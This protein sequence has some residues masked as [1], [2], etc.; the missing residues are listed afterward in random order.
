[1]RKASRF[2][3]LLL[4]SAYLVGAWSSQALASTAGVFQFVA[5]DV[6]VVLAEGSERPAA[7]GS[8][9]SVGD[10]VTTAKASTAQ[11]KMGD[12]AIIVV[13]PESKLTV[14]EFSYAGKED[15]TE[16]VQFRL[17]Q[18]GFRSVTGA[19]GHTN[20]GNYMIET[21]IA[22]IG[23]RGTDHESW[24]FPSSVSADG[25][26][27]DAGLYNKV[28]VGLTYIQTTS[29]EVVIGPNQVGYAST[30]LDRPHLLD[31]MPGFFNRSF[32]PRAVRSGVQA[33]ST[34]AAQ[35]SAASPTGTSGSLAGY[36]AP[37]GKEG[38]SFGE[39]AVNPA[40]SPNGATLVNAGSDST[41]GVN[42]GTWQGGLA[43]VNGRATRG[44]T[45]FIQTS[46]LTTAAQLAALPPQV[47][48][49]TYNYVSGSG[50]VSGTAS[51]TGT[52]NTLSVGINLTTQTITNYAVNATVGAQNW[53]ASGSGSFTQYQ[54]SS[55]ISIDGKCSGCVPGQGAP[56]A[57]GTATGA[58]VG[59]QAEGMITSFGM[60]AA[61]QSM[62]GVGA[63]SR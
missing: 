17:Q 50:G 4:F 30:A 43:T 46:N 60:K 10:T 24:Y 21:P 37:R 22:H 15:G 27:T 38:V 7:K 40:I 5:G 52:I 28:N 26:S 34:A 19:I 58:F 31:A 1:M 14:A 62:S 33:M 41:L 54:G 57:H 42:W 49:A 59:S 3:G 55:G 32:Q 39:T 16:R 56:T 48:T 36:T 20:K 2:T 35:G 47:V 53:N 63:L 12:G 44:D 6:R 11:I 25:V 18:G 13:Q 9:I 51:P 8:P 45:H 61:N 23:V 29:G